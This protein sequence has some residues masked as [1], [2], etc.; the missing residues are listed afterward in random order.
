[1]NYLNK[2]AEHLI[3]DVIKE[4]PI[5]LILATGLVEFMGPCNKCPASDI[6]DKLDK[7]G[8][9]CIDA[10]YMYLEDVEV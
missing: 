10:L 4:T 1:M 7:N 3:Q 2:R 6:C 5:N 8:H 9:T